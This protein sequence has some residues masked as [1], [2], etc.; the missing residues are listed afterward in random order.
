MEKINFVNNSEPY[1]SA[2]NLNQMQSNIEEATER[3]YILATL[4]ENVWGI[5]GKTNIIVPLDEI[6]QKKGE[7]FTLEGNKIKIGKGVSKIKVNANVFIN[8]FIGTGYAW[9]TLKKNDVGFATAITAK[10]TEV[11][12]YGSLC[13]S[14]LVIDVEEGDLI[15]IYFEQTYRDD[16]SFRATS[17]A[18]FL[19]VEEYY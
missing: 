10:I 7:K 17:N 3:G 4:K 1:L 11:P 19:F 5:P 16:C 13:I 2:E 14:P 8:D 6:S 12:P 18:T 9:V 15:Y